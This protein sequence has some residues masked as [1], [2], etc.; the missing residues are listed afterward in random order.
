MPQRKHWFDLHDPQASTPDVA[1]VGVPYD[2]SVSLRA[3]A[4]AAPDR[5]RAI[6]RTS[7]PITRRGQ[8]LAG[9]VVRDYGDVPITDEAGRAL[10][11]DALLERAKTRLLQLPPSSFPIVLGG[12]NSVSIAGLDAFVQRHGTNVGI[13][14]FD[15][16]PDLF[17]AYDGNPLSHASALYAPIA[18]H[19][20]DPSK[21]VL[22]GTRS[23]AREEIEFI[24]ER[25][26]RLI[27]AAEWHARPTAEVA[28]A[29]RKRMQNCDAVYVAIDID[30]FDAGAAPGTGYPM[31][32]GVATE[33]VFELLDRVYENC[34]VKAMDI[35]E[36]APPL[37]V[38]DQTTFLALQVVLES[39]ALGRR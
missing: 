25:N 37:D 33:R 22:A 23:F 17:A 4:A 3:G 8:D 7:D 11:Q 24:R 20:L 36:V 32:G 16:H 26:V 13:L 28:D 15:A 10:S 31:P 12:D 29:I 6:S 9:L 30:G 39:L 2:G 1:F 5:M 19:G 18:R 38:G 34:P 27:T 14:W 21:V 35:T